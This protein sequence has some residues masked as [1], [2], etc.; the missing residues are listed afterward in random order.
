MLPCSFRSQCNLLRIKYFTLIDVLL[1][2]ASLV[3]IFLNIQIEKLFKII[4]SVSMNANHQ[5][6]VLFFNHQHQHAK[7]KYFTYFLITQI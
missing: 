3:K 4:F 6:F 7:H 5:H 2:L 1:K